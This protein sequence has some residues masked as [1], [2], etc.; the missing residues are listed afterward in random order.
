MSSLTFVPRGPAFGY[1]PPTVPVLTSFEAYEAALNSVFRLALPGEP[2]IDLVLVKAT[3]T[4]D[5]GEHLTF[6][7]LFQGPPE[8]RPQ[9]S[10]RLLHEHLNEIDVFLVPVGRVRGGN[11][12]Y[13]AV[14]NL[15]HDVDAL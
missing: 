9:Q 11:I 6:T 5:T 1:A 15:V 13:E 12:Q 4:V 10:Y 8:P 7:L 14:F 3:K 2:D